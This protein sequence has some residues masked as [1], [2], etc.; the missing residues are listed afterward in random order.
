MAQSCFPG[1]F[2]NQIY[3]I[4]MTCAKSQKVDGV[5]ARALKSRLRTLENACKIDVKT[6]LHAEVAFY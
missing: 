3:G 5:Y 1:A 2:W 4:F 6:D